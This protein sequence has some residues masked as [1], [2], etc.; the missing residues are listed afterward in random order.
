[1]NGVLV[2][3]KPAG[4][5]S[6]DVVSRVRRALGQP[7]IGHTGTLDPL[8]TGVL[9]LVIGQACRLAQFYS[10][11][12]KEYVVDVRFGKTTPTY[13]AEGL[14]TGG[15][16]PAEP[17]GLSPSV[18]EQALP[19]FRGTF[20]QAPPPYSAKKIAGVRA[21]RLARSQKAADVKP[22]SVSVQLLELLSCDGG[23]ARLRI[24]CSS[25][26]YV[27]TLAHDLGERIG[28]GAHVEQLR[29]VRA[30]DFA[31]EDAVPLETIEAERTSAGNRLIPM[32]A[33]LPFIPQAVLTAEG[34]GR[35]RHGRALTAGDLA[36]PEAASPAGASPDRRVRLVD[37]SG[38]LLGIGERRADGLL[39]PVIVLV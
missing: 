22:V 26:F 27:R 28:C 39:H 3:D 37:Q 6:H 36:G 7:R 17:P 21:Y 19:S 38:I 11:A 5:T 15:A 33:L 12:D 23:L 16:P 20:L 24:V 13:D 34:A 18:V 8:A 1:M 30:G 2:V 31:I 14:E 9:P 10:A 4:P 35:A 25:G 32:A 29:R